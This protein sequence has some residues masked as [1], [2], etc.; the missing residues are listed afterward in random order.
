MQISTATCRLAC[1]N[2]VHMQKE[3]KELIVQKLE[4]PYQVNLIYKIHFDV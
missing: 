1:I 2:N 3:E 4:Y